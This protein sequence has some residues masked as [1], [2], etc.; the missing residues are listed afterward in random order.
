M[1]TRAEFAGRIAEPPAGR[2]ELQSQSAAS[3]ATQQSAAASIPDGIRSIVQQQLD[4]VATQR[5]AW[6]GEVWP[7]QTIDWAI[8]RDAVEDREATA[9]EAADS[10][11][12]STSLRLTMPRLGTVDVVV[13]LVGDR[14]KIR[15]AADEDAASDLRQQAVN[16]TDAMANAG[17]S[18]QSLEIRHEG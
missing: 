9:S 18:V 4:A 7:G 2:G 10:P 13:Q 16:L 3:G 6:H 11:H 1:A 14:L 15:L 8:Q 5:L 12:W 17:L